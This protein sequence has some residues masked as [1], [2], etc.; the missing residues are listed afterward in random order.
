MKKV[1]TFAAIAAASQVNAFDAE[2]MRGAQTGFFLS[3]EEQ[4][5]DYDCAPV[6]VDPKIQTY[7]DMAGP[8][9]MMMQNMNKGE[10][11]P[12]VDQALEMVQSFG[13]ISAIMD[14]SYEGG[15]FCK[16]LLFSK[17]ATKVLWK[18]G[19]QV[20]N[21]KKDEPVVDEKQ[22]KNLKANFLQ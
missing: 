22:K 5:K 12:M 1:A 7:I 13:K 10:P 17:E 2:F 8:M 18:I 21:Q 19:N 6:V 15:Q 14:E 20:M 4:F 16:G 3:S 11:N 9:K